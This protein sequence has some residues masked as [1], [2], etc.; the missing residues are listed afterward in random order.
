[1]T[2]CSA[3]VGGSTFGVV[4][5]KDISLPDSSLYNLM[6][7]AGV[8]YRGYHEGYKGSRHIH[9]LRLISYDV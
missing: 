4:S 8:T 5:N 3:L 1:M 9:R 6:D 2:S 7:A